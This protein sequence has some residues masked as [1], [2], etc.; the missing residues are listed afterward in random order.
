MKRHMLTFVI[1]LALCGWMSAQGQGQGSGPGDNSPGNPVNNGGS[2]PG[3]GNSG[4]NQGHQP[5]D[6]GGSGGGGGQG[7]NGGAGGSASAVSTSTSNASASSSS[8]SSSVSGS[9]AQGGN[10]QSSATGGAGGNA[11]AGAYSGGNRQNVSFVSPRNAPSGYAP[12]S[13]S[14]SPCRVA[15]SGAGSWLSGSAALGFSRDDEQCEFRALASAFAAIGNRQAAAHILCQTKVAKKLKLSDADCMAEE[16]P[17]PQAFVQ[18]TAA[19]AITVNVPP[20]QVIRE[21]VFP[22]QRFVPEPTPTPTPQSVKPKAKKMKKAPTNC[23]KG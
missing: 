2:D 1:V 6:P 4:N 10:A 18:P 21:E 14:T 8:Q 20:V 7:G 13:F 16:A 3:I 15:Y 23:P 19:P 12:A 17:E 9:Y 22:E 5:G 11:S